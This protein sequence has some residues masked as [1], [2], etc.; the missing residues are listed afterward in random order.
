MVKRKLVRN[1]DFVEYVC[2]QISGAGDITYKKMFGDYGVYCNLKL[3]LQLMQN[4]QC[5]K[6]RKK[7]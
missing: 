2:E 4:Y 3:Y 6:T 1:I 7:K 5:K